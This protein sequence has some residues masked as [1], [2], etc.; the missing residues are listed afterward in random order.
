MVGILQSHE[1]KEVRRDA[2]GALRRLATPR[3][4]DV[5]LDSLGKES[6]EITRELIIR[7]FGIVGVA[8]DLPALERMARDEASRFCKEAAVIATLL[9]RDRLAGSSDVGPAS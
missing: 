7:S 3:V 5:F 8:D 1:D 4:R 9:I 6:S 2:I